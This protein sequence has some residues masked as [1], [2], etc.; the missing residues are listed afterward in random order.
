MHTIDIFTI[1]R[2]YLK[3]VKCI[4]GLSS[5]LKKYVFYVL[6]K[7]LLFSHNQRVFFVALIGII[8]VRSSKLPCTHTLA[9]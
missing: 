7:Q 8:Y 5:R 9:I 4:S 1:L 6:K 2:L 3:Y